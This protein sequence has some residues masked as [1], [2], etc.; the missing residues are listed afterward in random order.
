MKTLMKDDNL[1][2]ILAELYGQLLIIHEL[3]GTFGGIDGILG[4]TPKKA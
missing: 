1:S 2:V 4:S 3:F